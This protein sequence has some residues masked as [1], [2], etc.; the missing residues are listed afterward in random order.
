MATH[1][2]GQLIFAFIIN[3]QPPEVLWGPN[4]KVLCYFITTMVQLY[5]HF[6]TLLAFVSH[7]AIVKKAIFFSPICCSLHSFCR[8]VMT[9]HSAIRLHSHTHTL[10]NHILHTSVGSSGMA[11][12]SYQRL[13]YSGTVYIDCSRYHLQVRCFYSY[14]VIAQQQISVECSDESF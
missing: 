14:Q 4:V 2:G 3:G 8:I 7:F 6:L 9:K 10:F 1:T 12:Y 11:D 5:P 13:A